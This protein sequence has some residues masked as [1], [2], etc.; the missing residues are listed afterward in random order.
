MKLSQFKEKLDN[1]EITDYDKYLAPSYSS[2]FRAELISRGILVNESLEL[3]EVDPILEAIRADMAQERYEGWKNY[4]HA[5][6][7]RLLAQKGYWPEF[8]IEDKHASVRVSVLYK[9]PEYVDQVLAKQSNYEPLL[10]YLLGV[11][12]PDATVIKTFLATPAPKGAKN[13]NQPEERKLL[14]F[15]LKV[16]ELQASP[17]ESTMSRRQLFEAKNPLW[18]R[19]LNVFMINN[20]LRILQG[21]RE[22]GCEL[23]VMEHF[24][25]LCDRQNH[26]NTRFSLEHKYGFKTPANV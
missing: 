22:K 14:E 9:H 11:E 6:V 15:K 21:A 1:K 10:N 20:V 2:S 7:R 16:I 3:N 25:D 13:G 26:Y 17:L 23:E 8:Y 12:H 4:P 5:S 24:N 19:D 18:A